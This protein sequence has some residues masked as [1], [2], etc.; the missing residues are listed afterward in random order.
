MWAKKGPKYDLCVC[1]C[2]AFSLFPPLPQCDRYENVELPDAPRY[3]PDL[4]PWMPA[5]SAVGASTCSSP[6]LLDFRYLNSNLCLY[7]L[8]AVFWSVHVTSLRTWPNCMFLITVQQSL[9]G[10][11]K[12]FC[13]NLWHFS[14]RLRVRTWFMLCD[15]I[16]PQHSITYLRSYLLT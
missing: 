13:G 3:D 7:P 2:V 4:P 16:I 6:V 15:R 1:V 11:C 8:K 14:P 10:Y 12:R 9:T 5:G